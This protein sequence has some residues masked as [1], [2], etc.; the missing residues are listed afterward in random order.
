[1]KYL[2][3]SRNICLCDFLAKKGKSI[4]VRVSVCVC[5]KHSGAHE[6]VSCIAS[7]CPFPSAISVSLQRALGIELVHPRSSLAASQNPRQREVD[8]SFTQLTDGGST[9]LS[10][11][12][13]DRALY[14]DVYEF[15]ARQR[16]F[17]HFYIDMFP[18][19]FSLVKYTLFITTFVLRYNNTLHSNDSSICLPLSLYFFPIK[20]FR[21]RSFG[22]WIILKKR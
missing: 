1:M 6:R 2:S 15:I 13:N 4:G 7:T 12:S 3:A 10:A 9:Y 16:R 19:H 11:R 22:N 20:F 17:R 5:V 8:T 18:F 21:K 14:S